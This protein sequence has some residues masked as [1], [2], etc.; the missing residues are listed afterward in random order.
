MRPTWSPDGE[1]IALG[2]TLTPSSASPLVTANKL[3][4]LKADSTPVAPQT[5]FE[6]TA[7]SI[8]FSAAWAHDGSSVFHTIET[9]TDINVARAGFD[10]SSNLM[11]PNGDGIYHWA[12]LPSRRM[13][14]NVLLLSNHAFE[15]NDIL[16]TNYWNLWDAATATPITRLTDHAGSAFAM[17][18]DGETV[19]VR[20]DRSPDG[21][22]TSSAQNIFRVT[23]STG[24]VQAI[25]S[26]PASVIQSVALSPDGTKFALAARLPLQAGEPLPAAGNLWVF[27]VDGT[28][29]TPL[30]A[31][32]Y[33]NVSFGG[34]KWDPAGGVIYALSG[35]ALNGAD[36]AGNASNIWRFEVAT[37]AA[38]PL[39][40]AT[41]SAHSL[42]DFD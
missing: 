31:L 42:T 13:G 32:R 6:T 8:V 22:G 35:R 20:S 18:P 38:T 33:A 23:R 30:T 37:A 36:Q 11:Q 5:L 34:L 14:K 25:T 4:W 40:G 19:Y 21:S 26:W 29:L 41:D 7:S 39:T 9:A 12:R 27:G 3:M 28:G 16:A 17:S 10:A 15:G 2:V 1:R 24:E